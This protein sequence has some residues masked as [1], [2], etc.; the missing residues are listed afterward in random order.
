MQPIQIIGIDEIKEEEEKSIIATIS[1]EYRSK[2]QVHF[3]DDV[4]IVLHV[5]QHSKGGTRKKSD[6]RV[7]VNAPSKMFEA[8]ESDWDL[9][10]TLH[11]VFKNIE[12][13]I[14]HKLK[15]V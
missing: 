1:E 14:E 10:R 2:I 5:K 7:K 12:R 3:K 13:E 4:S 15:V 6:I 11:K 8:Q 9:M